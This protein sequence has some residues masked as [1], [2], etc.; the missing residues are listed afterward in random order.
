MRFSLE[1]HLNEKFVKGF[2]FIFIILIPKV[3]SSHRV[4]DYRPIS[5][6]KCLYKVLTYKLK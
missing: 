1:F 6:V 4:T 3:V 5:L 2:N